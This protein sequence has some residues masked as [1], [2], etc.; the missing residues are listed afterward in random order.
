MRRGSQIN[1][2]VSPQDGRSVSVEEAVLDKFRLDGWRGYSG[3]GG[4]I[5]N[6]IKAMSFEKIA[7]RNRATYVEAVYAE[8]VAFDEDR[9]SPEVLLAHVATADRRTVERNFDLMASRKTL[10]I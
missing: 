6:L 10:T 1:N 3:E 8:N 9:F 7:P 2:W 4:L 5:L